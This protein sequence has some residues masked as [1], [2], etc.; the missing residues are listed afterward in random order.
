MVTD[1]NKNIAKLLICSMLIVGSYN[2]C[3]S[4]AYDYHSSENK[5][6]TNQADTYYEKGM[7]Y[8]RTNQFTNA[9]SELEKALKLKPSAQSIRNNLSVAYNSRA[10]YYLNKQYNLD[11]AANDYR[12]ALYYLK[13]Y[14]TSI[15]SKTIGTNLKIIEKNLLNTI[16]TS[17]ES[18]APDNRF[19]IAKQ[20]RGRGYFIQAVPEFHAALASQPHRLESYESLGDIMR[21]LQQ[22]YQAATFYDKALSI[23]SSKSQLHLKFARALNK[24]DNIDAAVTEYNIA[25]NDSANY[26]EVLPALETIWIDVIKE[27]PNNAMAH[28]NLGT[29]YQ[30]MKKLNKAMDEYKKAESINPSDPAIRLN[31]ATLYQAQGN[32][33][34]ALNAYDSILQL[35]PTDKI[36]HYYKSTALKEAGHLDMAIIELDT[37]LSLDPNDSNAKKELFSTITKSLEPKAA[38]DKM[39]QLVEKYPNDAEMAYNFAYLLHLNKNEDSALTYYN[40]SLELNAHNTDAYINIATILKNKG[41]LTKATSYVTTALKIDPSSQKAKMVFND[42]NNMTTISAYEDATKKY[43]AKDYQG[44]LKQYLSL[45][46]PN[47]DAYVGIGACYQ[48][49]KDNNKAIES[50]NKALS[51]DKRNANAYYYLG[52]IYASIKDYDKADSNYKQAKLLDPNNKNLDQ[53]IKELISLKN[54]ILI[55]KALD[56]YNTGR[57]YD[58]IKTL[59]IAK[60]NDP[61]SGYVMYYRGMAYD[62][63]KKLDIAIKN[64]EI[65]ISNEPNL[66]VAYYG[67]AVDYDTLGNAAQ[68]KFNYQ[69]YLE[70]TKD[71]TSEYTKYAKERLGQL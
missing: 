67:L 35:Y 51:M 23:D 26:S 25:M 28:M 58:A 16:K 21:I 64:Y 31:I 55:D 57:Y 38:M 60:A 14:D 1:M 3:A 41:D 52:T 61:E 50:Y 62:A 39:Y 53:S 10:T 66:D 56:Y 43:N 54:D 9:I 13:Y 42:I 12:A 29:V 69:K 18:I 5:Q 63:I 8:L 37:V 22:D 71:K 46:N 19:K 24:L 34:M 49:L 40:K 6:I 4:F 32:L 7:A 44:A 15:S 48:A 65:A 11:K 17:G 70:T 33:Q 45:E 36:A 47:S 68:A 30:K 27:E 20:L 2:S 59:N